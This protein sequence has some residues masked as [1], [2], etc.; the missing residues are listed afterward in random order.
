MFLK[1]YTSDVPASIT[2]GRIQALLIKI[3]VASISMEYG[4]KGE[5]TAITFHISIG[6]K[7]PIAIRMPADVES[8]VTALFLDYADG[9]KITPDG[10]RID[11][12]D[13]RRARKTRADFRD[14]GERTAWRLMQDWLEV[15]I[16]MI[17]LQQADPL[18]VFLPYAWD[19]EQSFYQRLK[20]GNFKALMPAADHP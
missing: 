16:S 10:N 18:Q 8:A 4:A 14:Q 15:Q 6:G 1:N 13:R 12:Y 7:K 2:I 19:G 5:I 3:G 11:T 20:A 9:Q 17:Q